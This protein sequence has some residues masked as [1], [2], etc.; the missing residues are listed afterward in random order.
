VRI[1]DKA[2]HPY[3]GFHSLCSAACPEL[4]KKAGAPLPRRAVG[5]GVAPGRRSVAVA[6]HQE[7]KEPGTGSGGSTD[8][9][10]EPRE[11]RDDVN[12]CI[13]G[14]PS[15]RNINDTPSSGRPRLHRRP[16]VSTAA[17]LFSSP[18]GLS[19]DAATSGRVVEEPCLVAG[20][21]AASW[22]HRG[23]GGS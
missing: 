2:N 13:A 17:F 14:T 3:W 23:S 22:L 4:K 7:G 12:N 11:E 5:G 21:R 16:T 15:R 6:P 19:Y 18:L 20:R 9:D 8:H 1:G 10:V